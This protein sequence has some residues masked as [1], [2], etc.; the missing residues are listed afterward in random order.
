M[1]KKTAIL[2]IGG[3]ASNVIC[4]S[5]PYQSIDRYILNPDLQCLERIKRDDIKTLQ[6]GK[7]LLKGLGA[8]ADPENGEAAALESIDEIREILIDYDKIIILACLGGG[9]GSGASIVVAKEAENLGIEMIVVGTTPFAWEGA[10]RIKVATD[11][12]EKLKEIT[13]NV[14]C[15]NNT[16]II[17]QLK[18]IGIKFNLASVFEAM[19]EYIMFPAEEFAKGKEIGEE[20]VERVT[21]KIQNR[22]RMEKLFQ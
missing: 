2:A 15:I 13:N 6:I 4:K 22:Y 1:D 21:K 18:T 3:G 5:M 20:L 7:E 19:D 17:N 12:I 8:A 11:A 14:Y 9:T 16:E 10:K